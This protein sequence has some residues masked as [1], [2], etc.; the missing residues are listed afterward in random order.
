MKNS[1]ASHTHANRTALVVSSGG[2]KLEGIFP[3]LT[4]T[5]YVVDFGGVRRCE[6]VE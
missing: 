6:E 5:R 3:A 2:S 1:V 4:E